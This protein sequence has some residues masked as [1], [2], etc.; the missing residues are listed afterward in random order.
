MRV[1][2]Q[3]TKQKLGLQIQDQLA[4]FDAGNVEQIVHHP[5]QQLPT[6]EGI[7]QNLVLLF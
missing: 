1:F 2:P 3:A 5:Q 7:A 6:A 4:R